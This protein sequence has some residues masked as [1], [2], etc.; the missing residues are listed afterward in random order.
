MKEKYVTPKMEVM[1]FESEDIICAST[2]EINYPS[3]SGGAGYT[4][5]A[6]TGFLNVD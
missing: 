2:P 1:E 6:N 4:V 5:D 3:M